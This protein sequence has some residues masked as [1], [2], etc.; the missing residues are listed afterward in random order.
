MLFV[1]SSENTKTAKAIFA[2]GCFWG[3]EYYFQQK[4]GVISTKVGYIGGYKDNP[5]YKEVCAHT[6]GHIEALEVTYD[7]DKVTYEDLA[8]LFFEIH[9]PTQVN[10]QGNDIGPQYVSVIFYLNQDQ[11]IISEK[12]I[13]TLELKGY[14]IATQLK[15]ATTFWPAEEYHQQYYQRGGGTPYCH[16]Y[17]KRF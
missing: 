9:D 6:T 3:V 15:E 13:H 16:K 17:T 2:G 7:I 12:L 5:T 8:K 10:G 1:E 4:E 14:K 11:K